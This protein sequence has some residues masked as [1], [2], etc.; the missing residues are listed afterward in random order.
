MPCQ[1]LRADGSG[2][3][4]FD[5]TRNLIFIDGGAQVVPGGALNALVIRNGAYTVVRDTP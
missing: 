1:F 4:L 3:P 5:P 2:D